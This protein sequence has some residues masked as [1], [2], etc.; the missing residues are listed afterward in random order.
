MKP[1]SVIFLII[2]AV[3]ILSGVIVC[4]VA[5]VISDGQDVELYCDYVDE[6][7][8]AVTEHEINGKNLTS[9]NINVDKAIVNVYGNSPKSY[10]KVENYPDKA[11]DL[12]LTAGKLNI[13]DADVMSIFSSLRINESGFGF[14]GLRH[15]LALGKYKNKDR[16]INIYL[17]EQDV[18]SNVQIDIENGEVNMHGFNVT[19]TIDIEVDNGSVT[20]DSITSDGK[21]NIRGENAVLTFD[22]CDIFDTIADISESGTINCVLVLQHIFTLNCSSSGN[23]YL[24]DI[25]ANAEYSGVYP[26]TPIVMP[27]PE[28]SESVEG[29]ESTETP[30]EDDVVAPVSFKGDVKYGD[31][32]ISVKDYEN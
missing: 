28:Q 9:I 32:K 8:N 17:S 3:L 16:I 27:V 7:G 20:L 2:S 14:D 21:A 5:G 26:E 10:V 30:A 19:T 29:E 4:C 23:V 24:D 22:S 31:I 18:L 25:K 11:Y 15:Y 13:E 6:T 12:W 1:T